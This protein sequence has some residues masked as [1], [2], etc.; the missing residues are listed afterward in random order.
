[1]QVRDVGRGTLPEAHHHP[2]LARDVLDTEACAATVAPHRTGQRL[3]RASGFDVAEARQ[4]LEQLRLLVGELGRRIE[5]LQRTA[6]A[7]AVVR[8]RGRHALGARHEHGLEHALVEVAMTTDA[9]QHDALT[10]Q[11]AGDE[12][13]LAVDPRDSVGLVGEI[14]DVGLLRGRADALHP[15][16]AVQAARNSARCGLAAPPSQLRTSSHSRSC[17]SGVSR[18]RSSSKRR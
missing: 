18:P 10:R 9:P 1:M 12:H 8:A 17:S 11:R 14:D 4:V 7:G 15:P 16:P 6:A 13:G 5:V 3:E 2:A